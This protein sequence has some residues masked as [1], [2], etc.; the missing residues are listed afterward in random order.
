MTAKLDKEK[1][2]KNQCDYY[3][4][5]AGRTAINRDLLENERKHQLI[6]KMTNE[7]EEALKKQW[8]LAEK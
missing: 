5:M 2:L 6:N 3:E 8:E 1:A 4:E 7:K